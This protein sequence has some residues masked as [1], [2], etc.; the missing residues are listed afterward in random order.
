MKD[1]LGNT[2]NSGTGGAKPMMGKTAGTWA[3]LRQGTGSIL[4][5]CLALVL[6]NADF[7]TG[8]NKTV[9]IINFIKFWSLS[10]CLFNKEEWEALM[11]HFG[12]I[13]KYHDCHE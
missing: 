9:K 10:T 13:S 3:Q 6:F 5:I 1:T 12:F 4:F 11:K 8:L 7:N 2:L